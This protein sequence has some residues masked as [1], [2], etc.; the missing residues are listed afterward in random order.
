MLQHFAHKSTI[1]FTGQKL[2]A[3]AH[4]DRGFVVAISPL[5]S[6]RDVCSSGKRFI[7]TFLLKL[8]TAEH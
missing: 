3:L 7:A 1:K 2:E 4:M 6:T 5:K 8:S